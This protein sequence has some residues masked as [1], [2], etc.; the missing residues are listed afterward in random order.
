LIDD[1]ELFSC[2]EEVCTVE[3]CC[4]LLGLPHGQEAIQSHDFLI[5]VMDQ[6]WTCGL[7]ET[8]F[9]WIASFNNYQCRTSVALEYKYIKS[10]C[11]L[12]NVLIEVYSDS[13]C[14]GI[15][16]FT[17]DYFSGSCVRSSDLGINSNAPF[18]RIG[19]GGCT[20]IAKSG[21]TVDGS[22]PNFSAQSQPAGPG[23]VTPDRKLPTVCADKPEYETQCEL[24][25]TKGYCSEPKNGR[26]ERKMSKNL[27]ILCGNCFR[28]C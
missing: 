3:E 26:N 11:M 16:E 4:E 8:N 2:Q 22:A 1:Y 12:G 21:I 9:N 17:K 25:S 28:L 18:V 23:G 6:D 19:D 14:T 10:R 13:A 27:S 15:P 7:E 5:Q 24:F 20:H